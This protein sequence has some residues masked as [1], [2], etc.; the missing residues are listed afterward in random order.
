MI[1]SIDNAMVRMPLAIIVLEEEPVE[2]ATQEEITHMRT[3]LPIERR[4][5][6]SV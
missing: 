1:M 3:H 4:A 6:G 2:S 5:W